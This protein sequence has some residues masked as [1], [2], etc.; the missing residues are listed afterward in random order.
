M[1]HREL[2]PTAP[3]SAR[4]IGARSRGLPQLH[5]AGRIPINS[6]SPA[7]GEAASDPRPGPA[8]PL[9][10]RRPQAP[11][12]AGGAPRLTWRR[13]TAPA[14]SSRSGTSGER[15]G[16]RP[17]GQEGSRGRDHPRRRG[18]WRLG[19]S[20]RRPGSTSRAGEKSRGG[21]CVSRFFPG[22][23]AFLEGERQGH[24]LSPSTLCA[25]PL[26]RRR[27]G[28][29]RCGHHIPKARG[30]GSRAP[31]LVRQRREFPARA[32][33]GAVPALPAPPRPVLPC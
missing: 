28:A 24:E 21:P 15:S 26:P 16:R 3:R 9:T 18:R 30:G 10:G 27:V 20:L 22:V 1:V 32:G 2:V 8:P 5:P 29:A 33:G 23:S 17:A 25:A 11:R 13:D 12:A 31:V 6:R 7:A 19:S 14:G 4:L